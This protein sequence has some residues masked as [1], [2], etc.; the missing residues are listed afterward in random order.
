MAIYLVQHG[1]AR[2]DGADAERAL[3]EEGRAD[4]ERIA[5]VARN[6]RVP[7]TE[8]R[9]SGK[10]R[11]QQ[12]AG[13][14]ADILGPGIPQRP[15]EGMNPGDDVALF[16]TRLDN[17]SN[18]MYVGHLPFMEKLTSHLLTGSSGHTIF[19]FQNGGIVCL[20]RDSTTRRW[21]I[22]WALMPKI[23]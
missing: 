6:Y 22:T 18:V 8:V 20:D 2:A 1:K 17:E 7:V 21:V 9:H 13:I 5:G 16:A 23:P 19:K 11:A 14:F 4:V 12:T 10:L 3:T 15:E